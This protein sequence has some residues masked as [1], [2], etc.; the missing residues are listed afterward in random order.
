MPDLR[1]ILAQNPVIA[2]VRDDDDLRE[3]LRSRV[4][5]VFVLYGSIVTLAGICEQLTQAGKDVFVHVDLIDGLKGDAAGVEYVR[6][7]SRPRGIIS[8]KVNVVRYARSIGLEA[9]LR[10]FILDSLSLRTGI[11]NIHD[12]RPDAVEVMP[13]VVCR[14]INDLEKQLTVPVIAGGLI[15]RKEQVFES[16]S[17]GATAISTTRR[18]LWGL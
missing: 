8:T 11:K 13:G 9:V 12:T 7:G 18:E 17:A 1:D 3:V 15:V 6:G 2:A 10:I 14:V 5:I 16:L 4:R